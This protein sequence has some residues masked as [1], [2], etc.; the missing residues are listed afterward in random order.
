MVFCVQGLVSATPSQLEEPALPGLFSPGSALVV[1]LQLQRTE[2]MIPGGALCS[3][4]EGEWG[5][6]VGWIYFHICHLSR[7]A[8]APASGRSGSTSPANA[9]G[10]KRAAYATGTCM[11]WPAA[12]TTAAQSAPSYPQ[13]GRHFTG[14][15]IRCLEPRGADCEGKRPWWSCWLAGAYA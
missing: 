13:P 4:T 9:H 15:I 3:N 12:F 14:W 7:D 2:P 11:A 6:T 1:H 10:R 8:E 5:R